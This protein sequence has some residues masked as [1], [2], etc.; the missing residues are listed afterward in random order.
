MGRG[1]MS[2]CTCQK[3]RITGKDTCMEALSSTEK[4]TSANTRTNLSSISPSKG[5]VDHLSSVACAAFQ[6]T[7]LKV[8][9]H[10]W[11]LAQAFHN[12]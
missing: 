7:L 9:A 6:P 10:T 3:M 8:P 11:W 2:N 5:G 1:E 12:P 4:N